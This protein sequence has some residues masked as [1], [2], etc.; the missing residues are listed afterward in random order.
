MRKVAGALIVAQFVLAVG[1]TSAP[2]GAAGATSC[3]TMSGVA[4]FSPPL[5]KLAVSKK[6][7]STVTV[8]GARLTG[9]VG[10]RVLSGTVAFTV[11]FSKPG[12]CTTLGNAVPST[13]SGKGVI[14]WNSDA[15]STV[16]GLTVSSVSQKPTSLKVAGKISAGLFKGS[17]IAETLIYSAPATGCTKTALS[18]VAFKQGTALMIK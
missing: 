18:K 9:C 1:L 12:N 8:K 14:T 4:T 3:K 15:V 2:A 5:P 16:A 17:K 11:K 13:A 10:G 7:V 6:V